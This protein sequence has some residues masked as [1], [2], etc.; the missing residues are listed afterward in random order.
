[1]LYDI[2]KL[3]SVVMSDIAKEPAEPTIRNG[4]VPY[5]DGIWFDDHD[6]I[7]VDTKYHGVTSEQGRTYSTLKPFFDSGEVISYQIIKFAK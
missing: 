7:R 3:F 2:F 5:Y 4:F 6:V 1:M